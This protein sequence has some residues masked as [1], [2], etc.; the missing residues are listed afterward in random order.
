MAKIAIDVA[1]LL[2]EKI[3]KICVSLNKTEGAGA[4]SDF[5]KSNNH[6]HITLAMGVIDEKDLPKIEA[7][8]KR[9]SNNFPTLKLKV[10]GIHSEINPENSK[11]CSF[12]VE[13]TEK[14]KKLHAE[15]MKTILPFLSH[16][17]EKKMFFLDSDEKFGK[18]SKYWVKN[19]WKKHSNPENY[20]PHISLKCRKANYLKFPITFSTSRLAVCQLGNYCACRKI[21]FQFNLKP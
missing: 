14:L 8:L 11:S 10:K 5:S 15:I 19:Y 20:K 21:F 7:K 3:N 13:R 4:F 9:I 16:T 18:V 12:L 6:Q 1:L 17:V 2:S